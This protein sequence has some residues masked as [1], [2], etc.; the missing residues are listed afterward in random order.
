M[1][2]RLFSLLV[3]S[4]WALICLK[5]QASNSSKL[6]KTAKLVLKYSIL[7]RNKYFDNYKMILIKINPF[8][9]EIQKHNIQH[10]V[11]D[12]LNPKFSTFVTGTR[13]EFL[14]CVKVWWGPWEQFLLDIHCRAEEGVHIAR[15]PGSSA[16][17]KVLEI[18]NKVL[19]NITIQPA[20]HLGKYLKHW[21]V[22]TDIHQCISE[23]KG[24]RER[25]RIPT[26]AIVSPNR[27]PWIC[28][29]VWYCLIPLSSTNIEL[30]HKSP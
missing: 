11:K 17:W 27:S 20:L 16:Y 1:C 5:F 23:E 19:W 4:R 21:K 6:Y 25:C 26:L 12:G 22:F 9:L 29:K 14:H 8:S 28:A 30:D 13:S 24:A 18:I 2:Q 7:N 10:R 15:E 3:N